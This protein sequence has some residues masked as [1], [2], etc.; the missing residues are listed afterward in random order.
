MIKGPVRG[1]VLTG[2]R[3]VGMKERRVT[4]F[5]LAIIAKVQIE[6]QYVESMFFVRISVGRIPDKIVLEGI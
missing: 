1:C 5:R 6:S 2:L 3:E 4:S